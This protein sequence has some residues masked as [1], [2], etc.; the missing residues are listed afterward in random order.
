MVVDVTSLMEAAT[1]KT[2]KFANS[3]TRIDT[4]VSEEEFNKIVPVVNKNWS[5]IKEERDKYIDHIIPY[6]YKDGDKW[7]YGV[8]TASKALKFAVLDVINTHKYSNKYVVSI[9]YNSLRGHK[10]AG[11]FFGDH[12]FIIYVEITDDFQIKDIDCELAG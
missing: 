4:E 9:W 5:K 3:E 7:E 8:N 1:G 12:C 2:F 11:K 6:W 10:D